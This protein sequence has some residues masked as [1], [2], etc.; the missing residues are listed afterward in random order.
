MR[1]RLSD[2]LRA[3][4]C[5]ALI[6][7]LAQLAIPMPSSVPI[8]LQTFAIALSGYCLRPKYGLLCMGAY[9]LLGLAGVPV[10]A[11]FGVGA[12]TLIGPTGGFLIGFVPLILCCSLAMACR[13][14]WQAAALSLLGLVCCHLCGT[15]WYCI[16]GRLAPIAA[17]LQV[18][19]PYLAKDAAS[20]VA[21][22]LLCR[23]LARALPALLPSRRPAA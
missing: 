17:F 9:L 13:R 4:L 23:A 10:F 12:A 18:S 1:H 8:T 3:A 5:T 7:V 16:V 6:A 22:Y 21:A 20:L 11:G 19:A 15:A 14:L 2:L